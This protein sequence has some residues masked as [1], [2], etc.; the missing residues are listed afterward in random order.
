MRN[1]SSDDWNATILII[2]IIFMGI[3]LASAMVDGVNLVSNQKIF[4]GIVSL[5]VFSIV[6]F[7]IIYSSL[8]SMFPS[9]LSG[10][11]AGQQKEKYDKFPHFGKELNNEKVSMIIEKSTFSDYVTKDG[12]TLKNVCVS[13]D[14]KWIC[15]LGGYLPADLICGYN[16][17][18][19]ELLAIDGA[20][21][22][23]PFKA[24]MPQIRRDL[25]A[26]FKDRGIYYKSLPKNAEDSYYKAR[27]TFGLYIDREDF[28]RVRYLWEKDLANEDNEYFT[29]DKN[30]NN[31]RAS[32][33]RDITFAIF[34]RVLSD[35]DILKIAENVRGG[36]TSLS[37]FL[38]FQNYLNEF[39]ACN[40]VELLEKIEY[41][42][43]AAGIDFLFDCLGDVDE[44]YFR[45][46][47]AALQGYPRHAVTM[48]IEE[49]VKLAYENYDV[50][51]L[52]GLMFLAKEI[53]YTIEYIAQMQEQKPLQEHGLS[54]AQNSPNLH[55]LPTKF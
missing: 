8:K 52:A 28:G 54:Q 50:V 35:N 16:A 23:L 4:E 31:C 41:P 55:T 51:G 12:E 25:D 9:L 21:I 47:V 13:D 32:D 3:S 11:R 1:N 49:K 34:E 19:N 6:A 15:I 7:Y 36:R 30:G 45:P 39:S 14:N 22:K 5:A 40:C 2:W 44:A 17:K 10:K 42:A 33:E 18:K 38:N 27:H 43:N 46:A 48:K 26:F 37:R 53:D 29:S 20:A 24:K